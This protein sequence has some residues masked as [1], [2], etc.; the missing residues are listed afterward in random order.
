MPISS[1]LAFDASFK[2][3]S[4]EITINSRVPFRKNSSPNPS[5]KIRHRRKNV[6]RCED[7]YNIIDDRWYVS[8]D[9]IS[10]VKSI[11]TLFRIRNSDTEVN[12]MQYTARCDFT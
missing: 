7:E 2:H 5:H 12:S 9:K 8:Y 4:L 6:R 3:R 1:S 11:F 10:S